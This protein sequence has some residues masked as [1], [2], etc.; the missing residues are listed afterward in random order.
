METSKMTLMPFLL[1]ISISFAGATATAEIP[2]SSQIAKLESNQPKGLAQKLID[3]RRELHRN[4]EL[5]NREVETMKRISAYL[6]KLGLSD[7]RVNVA[8]TG[9][10]ATLQGGKP[11]PTIA[12]RTPIDAFP[13]QEKHETPYKSVVPNVSHACGHDAMTAMVVGAAEILSAQRKRLAGQVEF[14][15]QPAEEG[16]PEGE[17]AGA[18]LMIKEGVLAK[19]SSV[20]ALH[21]DSDIPYGQV[22]LHPATVYAADDDLEITVQGKSA[23]GA[24][25]WKGVDS[26]AIAGQIISGLQMIASRQTDILD[27]LVLTIGTIQAGTRPNALAADAKFTGTLRTYSDERRKKARESIALI[28]QKFAEAFG[29]TAAVRAIDET[30]PTVNDPQLVKL[31][32]PVLEEGVGSSS[33]RTLQPM[34]YADDFAFMSEKVPSLYFQIGIRN[35]AK[36]ITAGTHTENFDVDEDAIPLG[37]QLLANLALKTLNR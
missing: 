18:L 5:G 2:A 36:G 21:V 32:R 19:V 35:D 15:F 16:A 17:E 20:L 1:A 28:A 11:G 25:P 27:P 9:V 6:T 10:V 26:I 23:H 3:F 4:P 30:P 12:L 24:T 22:G 13:I 14:I 8:K 29:G 7:I 31:L 37:A 33:V 34:P